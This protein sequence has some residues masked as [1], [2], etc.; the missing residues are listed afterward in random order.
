[1]CIPGD[2]ICYRPRGSA[3]GGA[4]FTTNDRK[5]LIHLLRAVQTARLWRRAVEEA[6]G[7][8]AAAAAEREE[9]YGAAPAPPSAPTEPASVA[10]PPPARNYAKDP[11]VRAFVA[12][13]KQDLNAIGVMTVKELHARLGRL[14]QLLEARG[15][16][17]WSD[18]LLRLARE[19]AETT[20]ENTGHIVFCSG[21][22]VDK[23]GGQH[24]IAVVH[25]TRHGRRDGNGVVTQGVQE[26]FRRF[27]LVRE[28]EGG[29]RSYWTREMVGARPLSPRGGGGTG[30]GA[31]ASPDGQ[32]G[33]QQQ[34]SPSQAPLAVS[35]DEGDDDNPNDD[36]EEDPDD[37]TVGQPS[38]E[39][40]Q[41]EEEEQDGG[42][43][44]DLAGQAMVEVVA[45]RMCF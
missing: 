20:C 40:V 19:C 16:S 22:A 35:D 8:A 26:Y 34:A 45:A 2:V 38:E 21:P 27:T 7:A 42:G 14:N 11:S 43:G 25:S 4:A 29:G 1:M 12:E 5:D 30:N 41:D 17:P 6:A 31:P 3:A 39:E 32:G 36:M 9:R 24:R 13:A 10:H 33:A 37:V 18:E 15:L 44:D 23:G 28:G